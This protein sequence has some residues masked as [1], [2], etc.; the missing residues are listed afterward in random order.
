M[1]G[2]SNSADDEAKSSEAQSDTRD[3]LRTIAFRLREIQRLMG[4]RVKQEN[5]R[6]EIEGLDPVSSTGFL[7]DVDR[8]GNISQTTINNA[9]DTLGNLDL[10]DQVRGTLDDGTTIEGEA[11][12]I[13]Y[14]PSEHLRV[15]L[16]SVDDSSV[17][18]ELITHYKSGKWGPLRVRRYRTGDDDWIPRGVLADIQVPP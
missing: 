16:E 3:E 10:G 5:R 2:N 13:D 11:S 8:L 1:V 17:R 15:E 9:V 12:P 14:M 4:M 6:L 18:Y 7:K